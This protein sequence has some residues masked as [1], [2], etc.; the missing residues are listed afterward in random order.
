MRSRAAVLLPLLVLVSAGGMSSSRARE[1]P[2]FRQTRETNSRTCHNHLLR[3]ALHLYIKGEGRNSRKID[4]ILMLSWTR[5]RSQHPHPS[6]STSTSTTLRAG[7]SCSEIEHFVSRPRDRLARSP[8]PVHDARLADRVPLAPVAQLLQASTTLDAD[9]RPRL[10]LWACAG[11]EHA[12]T[13]RCVRAASEGYDKNGMRVRNLGNFE[14]ER[15]GSVAL[16]A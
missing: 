15:A 11:V 7:K 2:S 5:W 10:R 1:G 12:A 6:G 14:R 4:F 13:A 9:V 8:Q 16:G 3:C